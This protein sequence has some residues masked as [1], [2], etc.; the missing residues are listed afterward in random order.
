MSK[1]VRL[2]EKDIEG[3]V[4]KIM[5]EEKNINEG[6]PLD[7]VRGMRFSDEQIGRDVLK[8]IQ[9]GEAKNIKPIGGSNPDSLRRVEGFEFDLG[10]YRMSVEYRVQVTPGMRLLKYYLLFIDG[11]EMKVST[12][13]LKKML[14]ELKNPTSKKK[15][16]KTS[17]SRY[18]MSPEERA[19]LEDPNTYFESYS[20]TEAWPKRELERKATSFRR[21]DF[22]PYKREKDVQ[23]I[24][25]KYSEDVPP[26]VIQYMR[27]NPASIIRRLVDIYG[28]D[29][30]YNYIDM[31]TGDTMSPPMTEAKKRKN[32]R[33]KHKK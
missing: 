30:I 16:L 19:R 13:I 5:S 14:G 12:N 15:D 20:L 9:Q 11:K 2:N 21:A 6:N 27:K 33:V 29:E 18:N 25:G 10:D 28:I 22:N 17:L 4:K 31:A 26:Q 1:V 8:G 23:K 3:L 24:F 32:I 7:W